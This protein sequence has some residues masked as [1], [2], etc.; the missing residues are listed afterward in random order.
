MILWVW[1]KI[2]PCL[3]VLSVDSVVLFPEQ[4]KEYRNILFQGN[5]IVVKG[6]R[7]KNGDGLIVEKCYIPKP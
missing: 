7:S 4:Y 5:V 2:E 6:S 1:S 3:K